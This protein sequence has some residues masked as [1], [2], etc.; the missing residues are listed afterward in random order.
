MPG[1]GKGIHGKSGTVMIGNAPV[2]EVTAWSLETKAG[3]AK[4]ASN[5]TAGYK[6]AV[7]GIKDSSGKIEV[8]VPSDQAAVPMPVGSAV[9]LILQIDNTN[10]VT[11]P[12]VITSSPL[13][14]KIEADEVVGMT[15][16]FEGAGAWNGAGV[17]AS[18]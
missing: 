7:P 15:Y 17:L 5:A 6:M 13:E 1:I 9:D 4:Y 18:L 12:A 16:N 11:V 2:L 10:M 3:V 8:K 14:V